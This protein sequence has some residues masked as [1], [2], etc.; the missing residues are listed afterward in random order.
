MGGGGGGDEGCCVQLL[1]L[2]LLLLRAQCVRHWKLQ[3]LGAVR[4]LVH[5][6]RGQQRLL[7][8]L[9]LLGVG[10]WVHLLL[11]W[12]LGDGQ[13]GGRLLL[14]LLGHLLLLLLGHLLLLWQRGR[15]RQALLQP[16]LLL[17]AVHVQGAVTTSGSWRGAT[18][19]LRQH[20]LRL[21]L[22]A[23]YQRLLCGTQRPLWLLL[24]TAQQLQ[25]LLLCAPQH[26]QLRAALQLRGPA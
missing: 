10:V 25:R 19:L 13:G 20:P 3:D 2:L 14:L 1:L 24:C 22:C 12:L 23:A 26:L 17:L 11:R 6:R 18:N 16:H 9:W 8:L 5:V 4:S 15:Q 7:L 21:L